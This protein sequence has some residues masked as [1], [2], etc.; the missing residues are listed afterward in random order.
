M[1][2]ILAG[3]AALA[4]CFT[5]K[6]GGTFGDS[7]DSRS[8]VERPGISVF[9]TIHQ[10]IFDSLSAIGRQIPFRQSVRVVSLETEVDSDATVERAET[11]ADAVRSMTHNA[12]FDERFASSLNG[13]FASAFDERPASSF[14]ERFASAFDEH[15]ASSFDKRREEADE[16]IAS[17]GA[18]SSTPLVAALLPPFKTFGTPAPLHPNDALPL[19]SANHE[20]VLPAIGRPPPESMVMR[21]PL[22]LK[23]PLS[24]GEAP[25]DSILLPDPDSRTAIYDIAAH[26]V[27]LP[28]GDRLEAHSGLGNNLDNPDDVK[29]KG[30]GPT[31][32]NVYSL[33]LRQQPFHGISAIRLI[34]IGDGNMFG[35]DGLLAHPYML[36]PNGQSNGCVSFSNYPAFLNAFLRGEVDRLVVVGHLATTPSANA[37]SG[38]LPEPLRNLFKL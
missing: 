19:Q 22:P 12:S 31:P 3:I 10:E 13:R 26:V 14:N 20:S 7:A 1:R 8:P 33:A 28:N 15:F 32:P 34:P 9:G 24:A 38:W 35:R 27:F 30:R 29:V 5:P 2:S 4:V 11:Q 25:H 18:L 21:T 36:G 17:S 6:S 37:G 16:S 23:R